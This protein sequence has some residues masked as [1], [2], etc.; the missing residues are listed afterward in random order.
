MRLSLVHLPLAAV[1]SLALAGCSEKSPGTHGQE[2][3][4]AMVKGVV[5]ETVQ[6]STLPET[7]EVSG[8]VHSRTSALVSARVAG[9]VSLL[10]VREGDRVRKGQLLAQLEA[11]ENQAQA[12]LALSGSD[13]AL[14]A[15]DDAMARKKL[16]DATFERYQKL[17]SEQA[18]TRQEFE[19]K[20]TERDLAAGGVARAEAR[21]KQAREGALAA[22][23]VADY[24]RIS[25][26]VSG[27]VTSKPVDLG[28][29]V[30]PGQPLLT[31]EDEGA[32]QLELAVP[33]NL[34]VRIK[35]GTPVQVSLDALSS[36]FSAK[37]TEIVPAADPGSR[38]FTAKI[39][40]SQKGLKSG[41]FGRGAISLGPGV[42]GLTVPRAAVAER[43]ALTSVWVVGNDNRAAMRLVKMGRT[44]GNR[45]EILG[46]LSAGERIAVSGVDKISEGNRVEP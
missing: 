13:E 12:S 33:E 6:T 27:I 32:Y 2:T 40:L 22:G 4:P 43:G 37:I 8:T 20:Q 29:T 1:L 15:L 41:M 31:I 45:V 18:V 19:V 34:A 35:P 23:A 10:K 21:L 39:P 7:I 16:T 36:S 9:T 11:L 24:T 44:V 5:L 25:A 14:R 42:T 26:P 17:F 46:G 38:T 3:P 28:A 30:F